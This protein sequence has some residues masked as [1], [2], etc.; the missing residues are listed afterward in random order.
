MTLVEVGSTAITDSVGQFHIPSVAGTY[1]LR[2]RRS[3]WIDTLMH[4]VQ[5]ARGETTQVSM[6]MNA[7]QIR[8]DVTSL[9]LVVHDRVETQAA[10]PLANTGDGLLSVTA[11]AHGSDGHGSWLAVS[12]PRTDVMPGDS[13]AFTVSVN[14]DS[15]SGGIV[16]F[17]GSVVL[18]DNACPDS[19]LNVA[20]IAYVLDVP[21]RP[22]R[23]PLRTEL[24]PAFPNPFNA[25]TMVTYDVA[26]PS[27]V[28]V[29]LFDVTGRVVRIIS[30][31][32]LAA[33]SYR[34]PLN[35]GD[36]ASGVYFLALQSGTERFSQKLLLIK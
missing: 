17:D 15:S 1:T 28:R 19:V 18:R 21:D 5:I 9:N 36:L 30:S 32:M 26:A 35:A 12:P 25:V 2:A 20:V 11:T 31:G 34:T 13:F 16:E 14:P 7:P 27:D 33:G 4:N 10:L 29:T 24:H 22:D 6:S 8:L 23:V 3:C